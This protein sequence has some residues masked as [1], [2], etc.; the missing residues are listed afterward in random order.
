MIGL[1]WSSHIDPD[2][3]FG[4]QVHCDGNFAARGRARTKRLQRRSSSITG[5]RRILSIATQ[6]YTTSQLRAGTFTQAPAPSGH[7]RGRQDRFQKK[8]PPARQSLI[9]PTTFLQV[10]YQHESLIKVVTDDSSF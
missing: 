7:P 1:Q 3:E 8:C 6:A 10:Q 9:V 5:L 4:Y 2:A